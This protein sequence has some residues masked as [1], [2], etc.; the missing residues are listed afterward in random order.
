MILHT[1]SILCFTKLNEELIYVSTIDLPPLSVNISTTGSTDFGQTFSLICTANLI[2]GLLLTWTKN[3]EPLDFHTISVTEMDEN[4]FKSLT[5]KFTSLTYDMSGVYI[6]LAEYNICI[7]N[8]A[9][10]KEVQ[11][12]LNV[13]SKFLNLLVTCNIF[14]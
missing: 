4:D 1:K 2:P 14:I 12:I 11:Y 3:N 9:E 13:T 10:S 5:A 6:C 8:D 7:T